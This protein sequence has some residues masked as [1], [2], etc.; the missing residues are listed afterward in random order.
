MTI[1]P[2]TNKQI[3]SGQQNRGKQ[4]STR[5]TTNRSGNSR[6]SITPGLD[7]T[8]GY[9]ITLKD[10]DT[11]ILSHVKK[12]MRPQI[13]EANEVIKVPVIYGNEERWKS[14]RKN[15]FLK[16]K[17]GAF[18]LPLIMLKRTDIGKN[19]LST[20]AFKH[21]VK[22]EHIEVVRNSQWSKK[23]RYDR[24]SVITGQKPQ[25]ENLVTGMPDFADITYEFVLWTNFIEQM[26][27][28]IEMFIEQ[29]NKY[30]GNSEQYKFLSSM[31]TITDASEIN[32]NGERFIKSTFSLTVSSYLL[33]EE[34]NSVVTGKISNLQKK[35]TPSRVVFGTEIDL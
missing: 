6:K 25:Y 1:K 5:N 31:D 11:A 35:L 9:S 23:N 2:I 18:M 21:D 15:G 16:D 20:Q 7:I 26:N 32:Q 27:P 3:V 4:T 22:R 24:F 29:S 28:L 34:I 10:I 30:W 33:P 17:Q 12:V 13:K 19:E 14:A 8:K